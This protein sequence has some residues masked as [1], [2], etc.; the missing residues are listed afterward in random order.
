MSKSPAPFIWY[1]L[2]TSDADA[3][4]RFYENLIGWAVAPAGGDPTANHGYRILT[5]PDGQGV[6]GMMKLPDGAP[7]P[8]CWLGYIGVDD[9]DAAVEEAKSAGA[10]VHMP[11][12]DIPGVGRFALLADPQ[13]APFYVMRGNSPEPSRAFSREAVGHCGWNELATSDQKGAFAF[14]TGQFGWTDGGTMPMGDMGDYQFINDAD[15]MIGA[16]MTRAPGGPPPLWQFYFRVPDIDAA[17]AK[18]APAGGSILHGPVEVPG[19]DHI[20][21]GMDPQGAAFALVGAKG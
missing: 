13:G 16:M 2:L 15:G 4:Q 20:V 6:G 5:A 21:V 19:G 12:Q 3:A 10:S 18:I 11:P 8:P 17:T 1:E 7:M 9:V 14:Y